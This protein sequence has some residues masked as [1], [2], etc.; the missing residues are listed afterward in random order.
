VGSAPNVLS[1]SDE[2]TKEEKK[3]KEAKKQQR[4]KDKEL[5]ERIVMR[6]VKFP[7]LRNEIYVQVLRLTRKKNFTSGKEEKEK[8]KGKKKEGEEEE[9]RRKSEEVKGERCVDILLFFCYLNNRIN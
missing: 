3:K 4:E 8:G 7:L 5:L 9:K 6:G 1:S 2:E